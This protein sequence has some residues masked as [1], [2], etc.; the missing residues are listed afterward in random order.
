MNTQLKGESPKLK[1]AAVPGVRADA[2]QSGTFSFHPSA[3]N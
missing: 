2:L 3:F 1:A